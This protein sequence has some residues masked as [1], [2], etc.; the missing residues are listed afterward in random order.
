MQCAD[1][2]VILLNIGGEKTAVVGCSDLWT[3]AICG[4]A[5]FV[6]DERD[7][8]WVRAAVQLMAVRVVRSSRCNRSNRFR[9]VDGPASGGE[10]QISFRTGNRRTELSK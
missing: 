8:F 4:R 3:S 2:W 5:R 7:L 10:R 6:F 1:G 9:F